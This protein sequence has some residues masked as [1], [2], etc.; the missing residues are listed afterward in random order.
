MTNTEGTV[1]KRRVDVAFLQC[2]DATVFAEPVMMTD[3]EEEC[4][5]TLLA[6]LQDFGLILQPHVAPR[7][8]CLDFDTRL[9]HLRPTTAY[10]RSGAR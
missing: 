9:A 7:Q 3:A 8:P 10:G 5:H 4:L 2:F 1:A 6:L